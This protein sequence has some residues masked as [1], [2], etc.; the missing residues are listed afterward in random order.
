[1]SHPQAP[2]RQPT[3]TEIEKYTRTIHNVAVF[4]VI[5]C[6]IIALLPPRKFDFYTF[7]LIG[8]TGYTANYLI[9]ESS[10]RSIWQHVTRQP[11]KPMLETPVKAEKA[12]VVAEIQ[13]QARGASA[14]TSAAEGTS[15]REAWKIQ[16]EKEIKEDVEE[17]KG[18]GD[19]IMDQ[20][21]E[22]WNQGKVEEEDEKED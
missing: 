1:M 5:A 17:G 13:K 12:S 7:T 14:S 16:R 20:I 3:P 4:A 15:Q 6:P 22:V 8:T 11:A 9:R 18:F 21:W 19:M 2:Q 10:G